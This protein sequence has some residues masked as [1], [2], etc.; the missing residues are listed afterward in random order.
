MEHLLLALASALDI[1]NLHQNFW[2][3]EIIIHILQMRNLRMWVIMQA[4]TQ[5]SNWDLCGPKSYTFFRVL[6]C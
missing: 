6:A 4:S 2:M 5:D 3:A 1:S